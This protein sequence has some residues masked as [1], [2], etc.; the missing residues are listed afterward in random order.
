MG[1]FANG[2]H[3]MGYQE[4]YCFRC[5]HWTATP[6]IPIEGCPVWDLHLWWNYDAQEDSDMGE[7][8]KTGLN[9]FIPLPDGD[10]GPCRMFIVREDERE[11]QTKHSCDG[12]P[13]LC[14]AEDVLHD[15]TID[16]TVDATHQDALD[17]ACEEVRHPKV[18]GG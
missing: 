17:E 4:R 11:S 7:F 14:A 12:C 6:D 9:S 2:T 5:V 13:V 8:V 16:G 1:Y 15:L 18:E 3:A 10:N